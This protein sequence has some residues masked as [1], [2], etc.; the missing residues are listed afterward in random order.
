ME[1]LTVKSFKADMVNVNPSS[2][3]NSLRWPSYIINS[4]DKTKLSCS[5]EN[6]KKN[7]IHVDNRFRQ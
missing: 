3:W 4:I 7:S 6:W 5:R 1:L 2:E